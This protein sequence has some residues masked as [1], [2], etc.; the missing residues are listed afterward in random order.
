VEVALDAPALGVGGGDDALAGVAQNVHALA[1][2][3]RAAVLGRLAGE[4]E[5]AHRFISVLR[6]AGAGASATAAAA[7]TTVATRA[8]PAT[9]TAPRA[10][11]RVSF[12]RLA[13]AGVPGTWTG[14]ATPR[15]PVSSRATASTRPMPS[16]LSTTPRRNTTPSRH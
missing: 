4:A 8:R 16:A 3:T 1:Q 5:L 6:Y 11:S 9:P 2:R 7:N 14:F 12:G 13:G 10:R 15:T